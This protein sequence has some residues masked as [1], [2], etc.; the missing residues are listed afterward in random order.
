MSELN[1]LYQDI[2]LEHNKNPRNWGTIDNPSATSE[3]FNPLCGDH[4][5]LF[6]KLENGRI[7]DVKFQSNGCAISKSSASIMT[8]LI[9][10]KTIEEAQEIYNEF[11]EIITKGCAEHEPTNENLEIFCG[12]KDYPSR[13]KCASLAWHTLEDALNKNP[14]NNK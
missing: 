5:N 7:T 1:D 14:E 4:I 13:V 11:H 3:G 8:T 6:L 2:I 10:G 9:K 12:V